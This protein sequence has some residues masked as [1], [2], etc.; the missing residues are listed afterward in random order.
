MGSGALPS[1]SN[2]LSL[3]HQGKL[4]SWLQ[5]ELI[6][7]PGGSC[8]TEGTKCLSELRSPLIPHFCCSSAHCST[9]LGKM[10]TPWAGE[11]MSPPQSR[12]RRCTAI[13]P[14]HGRTRQSETQNKLHQYCYYHIITG[15]KSFSIT[16]PA[17]DQPSQTSHGKAGNICLPSC[18]IALLITLSR[19]FPFSCIEND[20]ARTTKVHSWQIK[21]SFFISRGVKTC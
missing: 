5:S 12:S 19:V 6:S 14:G 9:L 18:Q 8:S 21:I 7:F 2:L 17:W 1:P 10:S 15:S 4:G 13:W 16:R 3:S 20:I 11:S